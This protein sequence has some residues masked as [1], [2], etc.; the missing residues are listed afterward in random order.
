M[1]DV[2]GKPCPCARHPG[3]PRTHGRWSARTIALSTEVYP[4]QDPATANYYL[5]Q[6][7][8]CQAIDKAVMKPEAV[9]TSNQELERRIEPGDQR[10]GHSAADAVNDGPPPYPIPTS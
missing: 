2:R 6:Q 8:A 9:R 1:R 4:G 5:G 10:G 3:P 7:A